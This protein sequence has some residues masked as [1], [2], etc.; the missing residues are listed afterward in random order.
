M[1]IDVY[2]AYYAA[3]CVYR[4]VPRRAVS[5][6]LTSDSENGH[7]TYT[8]SVSFFPH[9]ESYDYAVSYDAY[10]EQVVYDGKGRRSKKRETLL[11]ED[12][13]NVCDGLAGSLGGTIYWS[14]PLWIATQR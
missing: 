7:V 8:A 5:V 10:A 2:E 9:R 11:L 14:R 1:T 4:E 6:K 3:S 13:Q 12:L